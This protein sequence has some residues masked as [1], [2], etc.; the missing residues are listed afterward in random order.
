MIQIL[1]AYV[2]LRLTIAIAVPVLFIDTEWVQSMKMKCL[3]RGDLC[4][5][6]RAQNAVV[7]GL[8]WGKAFYFEAKA[9]RSKELKDYVVKGM[10][11]D[12]AERM[13]T[14]W[15]YVGAQFTEK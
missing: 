1:F 2:V 5:S 3:E 8:W 6:V 7:S 11:K 4:S 9:G 10:P 14:P 15:N 13:L 12:K